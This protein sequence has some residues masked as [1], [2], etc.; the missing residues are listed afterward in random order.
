MQPPSGSLLQLD[1]G[2]SDDQ[3]LPM[4]FDVNTDPAD[5]IKVMLDF[6]ALL[7]S[8]GHISSLYANMNSGRTRLKQN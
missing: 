6:Y 2:F 4:V 1:S 5:L 7:F 8:Y 3:N